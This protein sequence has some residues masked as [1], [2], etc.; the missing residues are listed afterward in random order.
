MQRLAMSI[1][2]REFNGGA[3]ATLS[4]VMRCVYGPAW[5]VAWGLIRGNHRVPFMAQPVLLAVL[6]WG[7]E[8]SVLPAV[9]AMAALRALPTRDIVG[10]LIQC[11]IFSVVTTTA[12]VILPRWPTNQSF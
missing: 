11:L 9:G 12:L 2:G 6:M 1:T 10:D 3:A 5:A 8:M 4:V 7:F